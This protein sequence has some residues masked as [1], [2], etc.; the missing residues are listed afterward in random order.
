[1]LRTSWL[2]E[3]DYLEWK[4]RYDL[5]TR[6]GAAAASKHLIGFA[7]RD[8]AQAARRADGHAYLLLGVEPS[9]L[10]GVQRWDSA[11][12]ENWLVRFVGREL[13]Y[14][15]HYVEVDGKQVLF[16][17]IEP[18]R[19]GDPIYCMQRASSEPGGSSLPDGAIYVRHGGLTDVASAADIARLTARAMAAA[20]T[21]ALRVD[22]ETNLLKVMGKAVLSQEVRDAFVERERKRLLGTLP[23]EQSSYGSFSFSPALLSEKRSREEFINEVEA[24]AA[25][26]RSRWTSVVAAH[27]VEHEQS[28][29]ISLVVNETDENFE[30]V[31]V[32]LTLP[33]S[34]TW[35]YT[36][37][38]EANARLKPPE[39]PDE[40]GKGL[41]VSLTRAPITP[42]KAGHPP[43][44]EVE[45]NDKLTLVRFPPLH[46]RPHT[47][48]RLQALLLALPPALAGEHLPVR[49]RATAR[50]TPGQ[51]HGHVE[52][53]IPGLEHASDLGP[54]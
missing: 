3:T 33:F 32:E 38:Y 27:Q 24:Y 21:L 37:R 39:P 7:N 8:F 13:R 51:L 35:V 40:W 41:L 25:A 47:S 52:L 49:W 17:T 14:D 34:R 54:T 31:V 9:N 29:L 16:L 53:T 45:E 20:T 15:I 6:P 5:S 1:M 18:P 46:V 30:D 22:L 36:G 44:P 19:Q 11:D 10:A 26:V 50:N 4:T 48:H 28:K 43:E 12:V 42:L 23:K 2:Q